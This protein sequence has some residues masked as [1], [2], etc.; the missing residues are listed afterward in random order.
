MQSGAGSG[1][2][3]VVDRWQQQSL[4]VVGVNGREDRAAD[5]GYVDVF[6]IF[7][8]LNTFLLWIFFRPFSQQ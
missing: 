6:F 2:Q 7:F 4:D 8:I 3:A 5:P 1:W